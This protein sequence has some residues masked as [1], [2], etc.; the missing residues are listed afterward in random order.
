[1]KRL[2]TTIISLICAYGFFWLVWDIWLGEDNKSS[3]MYII[4][5][6]IVCTNIILDKIGKMNNEK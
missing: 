2:I 3:E 1:M 4:T 6:I 5:L